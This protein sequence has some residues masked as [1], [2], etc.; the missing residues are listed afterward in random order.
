MKRE[1]AIRYVTADAA[2]GA[3]FFEEFVEFYDGEIHPKGLGVRCV[4][5]NAAG[6]KLGVAGANTFTLTEPIELMRC[7][8]YVTLKASVRKPVKV[9]TYLYPLGDRV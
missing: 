3:K 7:F 8:R 1:T 6:R 9:T 5:D 2:N 4:M